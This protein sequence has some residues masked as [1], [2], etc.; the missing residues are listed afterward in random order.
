MNKKPK[1][2][3]VT[4]KPKNK[5]KINKD[6]LGR[7]ITTLIGGQTLV[8][9]H[10]AG[11]CHGEF[12]T[13]HNNSV[14]HMIEWPQNWRSDRR[15]MERICPEHHV[16]HPDPDDPTIIKFEYERI[17]GCCGCC[18]PDYRAIKKD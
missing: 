15:I 14:H 2:G 18:N 8:N 16:G 17:H 11:Q 9:V 13:I 6:A 1:G 7:Q 12:C 10:S 5:K 4:K 3:V